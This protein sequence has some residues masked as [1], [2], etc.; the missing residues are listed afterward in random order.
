MSWSFY[1]LVLL[2]L[3]KLL[4]RKLSPLVSSAEKNKLHRY[5]SES[6]GYANAV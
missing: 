2:Y 6:L 4:S 5:V 3:L 1:S